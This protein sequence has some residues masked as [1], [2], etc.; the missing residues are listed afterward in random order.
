MSPRPK[1]RIPRPSG[2]NR[3]ERKA[4][5]AFRASGVD[6]IPDGDY[7]ISGL[8]K[9]AETYD[10]EYCPFCDAYRNDVSIG[11]MVRNDDGSDVAEAKACC[12]KCKREWKVTFQYTFGIVCPDEKEEANE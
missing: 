11:P 4:Y 5:L 7:L 6:H 3:L 1:R 12:K 10:G 8:S 9:L 2:L